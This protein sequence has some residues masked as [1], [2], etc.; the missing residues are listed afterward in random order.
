MNLISRNK[1]K[2]E[3][4]PTPSTGGESSPI[5][6]AE[7]SVALPTVTAPSTSARKANVSSNPSVALLRRLLITRTIQNRTRGETFFNVF[8]D[9]IAGTFLGILLVFFLFSL[10]YHHFIQLGSARTFRDAAFYLITDPRTIR[11]V[12]N[13]LRLKFISVDIYNAKSDELKRMLTKIKN[14]QRDIEIDEKKVNEILIDATPFD[15]EYDELMVRANHLFGLDN[16]CVNCKFKGSTTCGGRMNYL[17]DKYGDSQLKS[18]V[19][20]LSFPQCKN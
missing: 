9:I 1:V 8:K 12:E 11:Y 10:D 16:F 20:M 15:Q 19:A 7:E 4:S 17:M 2:P 5:A 3:S 6:I 13:S 18:K 14:K